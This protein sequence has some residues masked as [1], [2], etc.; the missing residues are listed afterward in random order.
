MNH[1]TILNRQGQAMTECPM[2]GSFAKAEKLL[3]TKGRERRFFSPKA[4]NMLKIRQLANCKIG[5][6]QYEVVSGK[7]AL[8]TG[9]RWHYFGPQEWKSAVRSCNCSCII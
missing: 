1:C 9:I 8:K 3:K 2:D 6:M 4:E 7:R 5:K